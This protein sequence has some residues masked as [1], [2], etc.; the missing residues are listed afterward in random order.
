MMRDRKP[1]QDTCY[2]LTSKSLAADSGRC[3]YS[4]V[5]DHDLPPKSNSLVK[6]REFCI[7]FS[8]QKGNNRS[9]RGQVSKLDRVADHH[10]VFSLPVCDIFIDR[11]LSYG[12]YT[13]SFWFAIYCIARFKGRRSSLRSR[14][15][16]SYLGFVYI[17]VL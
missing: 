14:H 10:N 16:I 11:S 5:P 12:Y 15:G 2:F 13:W 3:I 4:L 1:P 8:R 6:Q 9:H 17:T 7:L